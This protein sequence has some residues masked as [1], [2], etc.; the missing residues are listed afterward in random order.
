MVNGRGD[1]PPYLPTPFQEPPPEP[2]RPPEPPKPEVQKIQERIALR[3]VQ[4]TKLFTPQEL[5]KAGLKTP[6]KNWEVEGYQP[7]YYKTPDGRQAL[8]SDV[9]RAR[10]TNAQMEKPL[11]QLAN[12]TLRD[13][14]TIT[15]ITGVAPGDSRRTIEEKIRPPGPGQLTKG[16]LSVKQYNKLFGR[17][18]PQKV[19]AK[20]E[21]VLEKVPERDKQAEYLKR[22]RE[23]IEKAATKKETL[24]PLE[25][26]K[27][28][29]KTYDI[30]RAIKE[31][32]IEAVRK[33]G[34]EKGDILGAQVFA[35]DHTLLPDGQW[36]KNEDIRTIQGYSP[37]AYKT[38][39]QEGYDSYI[40]QRAEALKDLSKHRISGKWGI[41]YNLLDAVYAGKKDAVEIIFGKGIADKASQFSRVKVSFDPEV[42]KLKA[43]STAAAAAVPFAIAEPTPAGEAIIALVAAAALGG[44]YF[45]NRGAVNKAISE[46]VSEFR[47][48]F[49]RNPTTDEVMIAGESGKLATISSFKEVRD[50]LGK[51]YLPHPVKTVSGYIPGLKAKLAKGETP[52]FSIKAIKQEMTTIPAISPTDIDKFWG[53]TVTYTE[54]VI[55]LPGTLTPIPKSLIAK[56]QQTIAEAT[57]TMQAVGQSASKA[58]GIAELPQ[59]RAQYEA[60]ELR[61]R[62]IQV[63]KQQEKIKA[64]FQEIERAQQAGIVRVGE[65]KRAR[66]RFEKEKLELEKRKQE[67]EQ[68][69]RVSK[70]TSGNPAFK[71][72]LAEITSLQ[73]Q[74]VRDFY[75]KKY[76]VDINSASVR[77]SIRAYLESRVSFNDAVKEWNDTIEQY[78][79]RGKEGKEISPI[80]AA[81]GKTATSLE[82][83]ASTLSQNA[84]KS[85][86]REMT[87][88]QVSTL[89]QVL[90]QTLTDTLIKTQTN[91]LT[92][93]QMQTLTRSLIN[94]LTNKAVA[95]RALTR[96]AVKE[97]VNTAVG[98]LTNATT[99]TTT[100]TGEIK[101]SGG[102]VEEEEW[103]PEEIKSAIAWKA[104]II[105]HALKYP[106]RRG[107]DERSY[108]IDKAPPG[109]NVMNLKGKGSQQASVRVIGPIPK[110][111]TVDV[112]FEDVIISKGNRRGVQLRH[113]K[114]KRNSTSQLTIKRAR[115]ISKK[116]GRIYS[117]STS[118]GKILSRR[119]LGGY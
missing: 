19:A 110:R 116:K 56:G 38:L 101:L 37:L 57:G 3:A 47:E 114:D 64:A 88:S 93:A 12:V 119:P 4:E 59:T 36:L 24:K 43:V 95:S 7:W 51:G 15:S 70:A 106:Y 78:T 27:N 17:E 53:K 46:A 68:A 82:N 99:T 8:L 60:L 86:S 22:G 77:D 113:Y 30:A 26:Y 55:I 100:T 20:I 102:E 42:A 16:G 91:S 74:N 69:R 65:I 87:Q 25:D 44:A 49:G 72:A 104:G 58:I 9:V 75:L 2:P 39:K 6:P 45:K 35:S 90:T 71:A 117:T 18:S 29:D 52:G 94:E 76:G 11:P 10:E 31:G 111:L 28:P 84:I 5:E 85:L 13:V 79:T 108:H 67:L 118:G 103:T 107:I 61:I 14:A 97:A 1:I 98:E 96:T 32:N 112:G 48:K 66:A 40:K 63:A 41:Q 62:Q 109:L 33:A 80:Y 73:G 105:V 81:G 50:L 21:K 115:T 89:E 83:Q 34:F 92:K 54:P 23:F